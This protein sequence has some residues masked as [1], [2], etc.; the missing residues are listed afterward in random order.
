MPINVGRRMFLQQVAQSIGRIPSLNP[1]S[2][3]PKIV[4]LTNLMSAEQVDDMKN[5]TLVVV[6][7]S[8]G[9]D[10]INTLVPYSQ[11]AYYDARPTLALRS[12]RCFS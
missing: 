7:L 9:N 6:Q 12:L 8:G 5:R 3:G 4:D 1:L 10:G 11:Q 2:L